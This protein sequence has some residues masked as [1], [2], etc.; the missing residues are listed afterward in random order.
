MAHL[1]HCAQ[2]FLVS[3]KLVISILMM[4]ENSGKSPLKYNEILKGTRNLENMYVI[5]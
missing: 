3:R 1:T 4:G 2:W 5:V